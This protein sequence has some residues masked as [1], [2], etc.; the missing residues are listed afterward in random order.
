V[1]ILKFKNYFLLNLQKILGIKNII[2]NP[3]YIVIDPSNICQLQCPFCDG[4]LRPQVI[5]K[6][7]KFKNIIDSLGKTCINLE[8]YN[9]GE[10]FLNKDIIEMINYASQKYS[11]YTRISSN[12]NIRNEKFYKA[13]VLSRL[14]SLTISLD[15]ASQ[16]T[17]EKYR[18]NGSFDKVIDNIQLIV[19]YKKHY[20]KLEPKLVWQFLVFRHNEH[21]IEKAKQMA[22]ELKVNEIIFQ[23]PN[24]P[25]EHTNWDSNIKKFSNFSR[26]K[27]NEEGIELLPKNKCN[28]PFSSVAINANGSVSPCCA[29]A[30]EE[31]D[32]G[33]I[34]ASS[35]SEIW[36]NNK[37]TLAREIVLQNKLNKGIQNICARCEM[38][39]LINFAPNFLQVLYYSIRPLRM[40]WM[41][42]NKFKIRNY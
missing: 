31:D 11:I 42:L 41:R 4:R 7:D 21:E 6:L 25:I 13:L 14:N 12:L 26:D 5:M 18:V 29:V 1:I 15:G 39:G 30:K 10:P 9:W 36:N 34:F 35:F 37:F 33:N 22:K 17:Y 16:E 38:K 28:W 20:R 19:K 27:I 2:A 32:F 24:I 40:A 3:Y 23:R 8:L